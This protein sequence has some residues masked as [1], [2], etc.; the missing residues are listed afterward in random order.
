MPN[1]IV[2]MKTLWSSACSLY[3]YS[4]FSPVVNMDGEWEGS[5]LITVFYWVGGYQDP[6]LC[7]CEES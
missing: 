4:A 6:T 2:Q 3:K 7:G 5:G 1:M